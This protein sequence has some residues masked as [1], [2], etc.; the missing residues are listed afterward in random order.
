MKRKMIM[1]LTLI[2]G[3]LIFA[4][5]S[6]GDNSDSGETRQPTTQQDTQGTT[7]DTTQDTT[8]GDETPEAPP[9]DEIAAPASLVPETL[10]NPNIHIIY[11]RGERAYQTSRVTNPNIWDPVW[12]T[13]G[14]FEERFGGTVN[15]EFANW[16]DMIQ[17]MTE[18]QS[19]GSPP[20]LVMVFDRAMHNLIFQGSLMPLTDFVVDEDFE[21]WGVGR[22]L[23]SWRGE[24]YAI[25]WKPYLTSLMFN[26]DLLELYGQ[27]MPDELFRAG[28]WTFERFAEMVMATTHYV[29]GNPVTLGFGSWAG[30]GLSRFLVANG[31][32]FMDV[33]TPAGVVTS[34]FESQILI[35]TLDWV[36]TWGGGPQSGWVTGADMF[37][38]FE[39]GGLAFID[40][41]EYG[42]VEFPFS[43]GMVP[44][45]RGPHSPVDTPI[46]VMPQGMGVPNGASNPEGAVAFMRMLNENWRDNGQRY[47]VNLIGQ[48]NFN[49]IYAN[50]NARMVYAFDKST[51][52]VDFIFGSAINMLGDNTPASTIAETLN[53]ELIA[54]I[55]LVFGGN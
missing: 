17:R 49:M 36:R 12:E 11:W 14:M 54:D 4:A 7:Q 44:Y 52:N 31:S 19:A 53:P 45:P 27:P 30:E 3:L 26:R 10:D 39:A 22:D 13:V 20:D 2:A 40:G 48:E 1:V 32:A 9:A 23:V 5:C 6:G 38:W 33:N 15:V 34:G 28:E 51:P 43:V 21:F 42:G 46:V 25:P 47:T 29:D 16:N 35:D 24:P 41:H 50:P 8:T 18:L 37:G 55:N